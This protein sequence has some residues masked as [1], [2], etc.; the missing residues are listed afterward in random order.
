MTWRD[1]VLDNPAAKG[2]R[3]VRVAVTKSR[4]RFAKHHAKVAAPISGR[5]HLVDPKGENVAVVQ[6]HR[7]RQRRRR[8]AFQKGACVAKSG[9]EVLHLDEA[10]LQPRTTNEVARQT[11]G[12]D[13]VALVK[14]FAGG[15]DE[16]VRWYRSNPIPSFG[17]RTP[18]ALVNEGKASAVRKFVDRILLGGFA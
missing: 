14:Q 15:H 3:S 4:A 7:F 1:D 5:F 6:V 16:A 10:V 8:I 11:E 2:K 13:I 18:E 9:V 17:Y 12:D